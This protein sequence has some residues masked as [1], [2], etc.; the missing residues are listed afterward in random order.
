MRT[1]VYS[2]IIGVGVSVLL[3]CFSDELFGLFTQ[4]P[5]VLRLGKQ[6]MFIEIFL[7]AGRAVNMTQVRALQ[8]AGDIQF[9]ILLGIA[10]QWGVAV[11]LSYLLAV[12][13]KLGVVGVWLAMM[14]D[15]VL[16]AILFLM[17]WYSGKWKKQN[18]I[19]N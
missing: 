3:Y 19:E 16:R 7:E 2:L 1:L 10:S 14:I 11:A 6:V 8:A 13:F 9:P 17:R 5:T 18:L 15:E 12:T 4:D